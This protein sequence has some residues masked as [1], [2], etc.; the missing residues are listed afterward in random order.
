MLTCLKSF[1]LMVDID[2][3]NEDIM[4]ASTEAGEMDEDE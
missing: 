2:A 4:A 1:S 3:W